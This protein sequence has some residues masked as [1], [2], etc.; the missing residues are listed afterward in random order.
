MGGEVD[1]RR[2]GLGGGD[3]WAAKSGLYLPIGLFEVASY[4]SEKC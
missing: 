4:E 1:G 3:R 2:G